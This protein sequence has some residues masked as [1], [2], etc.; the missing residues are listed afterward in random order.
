MFGPV[1]KRHFIYTFFNPTIYII[2]PIY[3][4]KR[5]VLINTGGG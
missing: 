4:M 1:A 2:P 5:S 3:G